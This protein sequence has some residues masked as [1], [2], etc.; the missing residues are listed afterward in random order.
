MGVL[1][2]NL[3]SG[4]D[5]IELRDGP[6]VGIATALC[7]GSTMAI[8]CLHY[9]TSSFARIVRNLGNCEESFNVIH[10]KYF[11]FHFAGLWNGWLLVMSLIVVLLA[12][13]TNSELPTVAPSLCLVRCPRL[14]LL[15]VDGVLAN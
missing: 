6:D 13:D 11:G 5:A 4:S 3:L 1:W 10:T 8:H 15:V 9:T 14:A 7:N 2:V 12:L